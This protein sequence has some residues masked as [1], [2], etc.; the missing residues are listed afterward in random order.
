LKYLLRLT[1]NS[2]TRE[3]EMKRREKSNPLLGDLQGP[4]WEIERSE[5][6][7]KRRKS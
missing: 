6:E 2:W 3:E 7:T 1:D 5:P 4:K